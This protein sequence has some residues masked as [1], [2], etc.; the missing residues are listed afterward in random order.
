MRN[1][2]LPDAFD[3]QPATERL[4]IERAARRAA[5]VAAEGSL[6]KLIHLVAQFRCCQCEAPIPREFITASLSVGP[7][8]RIV[9]AYCDHCKLLFEVTA[10]L[11]GLNLWEQA[12]E[13]MIVRDP[14]IRRRHFAQVNAAFNRLGFGPAA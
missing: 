3:D 5:A 13:A 4:P 8:Q 11:N 9:R 12:S 7:D 10:Q 14:R 6:A 2:T 1:I